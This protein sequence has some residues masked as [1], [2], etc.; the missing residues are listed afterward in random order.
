VFEFEVQDA[1]HIR[2]RVGRWQF[3]TW[4]SRVMRLPNGYRPAEVCYAVELHDDEDGNS[5]GQVGAFFTLEAAEACLAQLESE[6]RTNL[7]I[8]LIPVHLRL[9]DWQFDR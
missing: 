7:V 8:N 6:G 1:R 2:L 3:R 9:E 5:L 4:R